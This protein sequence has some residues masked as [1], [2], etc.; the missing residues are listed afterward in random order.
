MYVDAAGISVK[1]GAHYPGSPHSMPL[2]LLSPRGGGMCR[3][4]SAEAIV[5]RTTTDEGPNLMLRTG[6]FV[7][8]VR[9]DIGG[10]AEKRGACAE[11]PG[12]NLGEGRRSMSRH[13][14]AEGDPVP[15]EAYEPSLSET[16]L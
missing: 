11:G 1:V 16:L 12:R 3:E 7:V 2:V 8:R 6:A 10:R 14:L 5:V 13:P 9:G 4:E 15:E